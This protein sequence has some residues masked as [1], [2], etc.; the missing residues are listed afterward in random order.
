M[1]SASLSMGGGMCCSR[2]W[3]CIGRVDLHGTLG[4]SRR[5][6]CSRIFAVGPI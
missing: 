6:L 5:L 4:V 1:V 2:F 3:F